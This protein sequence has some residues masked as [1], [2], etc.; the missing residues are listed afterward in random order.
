MRVGFVLL[1]LLMTAL[2][3]EAQTWRV[4]SPDKRISVELP[5]PLRR[6]TFF[7]GKHGASNEPD[8]DADKEVFSYAALQPESKGR[9]YGV[10]VIAG[11]PKKIRPAE[12]QKRIAGLDFVIG[13]DDATP[14]SE[15][16]IRVNGLLGKE[17]VYAKEIADQVYTR[18]RI[19]DLGDRVYVIVF[20]ARIAEDLNSA[21]AK[22][23][24]NSFR[25]LR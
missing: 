11:G 18:G 9:E 7:E 25:S 5:A 4:Y 15:R 10:I 3:C 8:V 6:V 12:R 19:F 2:E 1:T 14:T 22:R 20:R 23:F 16:A 24:L 21:D 13:G 17:Y